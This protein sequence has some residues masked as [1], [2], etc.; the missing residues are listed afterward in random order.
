MVFKQGCKKMKLAQSIPYLLLPFFLLLII[1][2]TVSA[3]NVKL[4]NG[5]PSGEVLE[6]QEINYTI[7]ISNISSAAEKISFETDL[8]KINNFHLYNFTNLNFTSD[9][10]KFDFP[11]DG[12]T[13]SIIVNIHGQI[14]QITETNQPEGIKIIKY[15]S[16]TGYVFDRVILTNNKGDLI[17]TV[18]TRSFEISIP[19]V[20]DFREKINKINDP[21][22]KEYLQDLHDKGLVEES[23]T[24]ADHLIENSEWSPYWWAFPGI[25]IGLVI[26]GLVGLRIGYKEKVGTPDETEEGED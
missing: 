1:G 14:P 4:V 5:Q 26:G 25:I 20:E 22:F 15:K 18:E 12:N 8:A 24:L 6:G 10:N 17:E 21:F 11:V 16:Q 13:K 19:E 7:I 9:I 2:S 3:A 23:N